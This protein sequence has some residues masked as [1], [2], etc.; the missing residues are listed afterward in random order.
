MLI[1]VLPSSGVRFG[2][3]C[4]EYPGF[5]FENLGFC[6]ENLESCFEHLEFCFENIFLIIVPERAGQHN[7][8][9]SYKR[10]W[11][12]SWRHAGCIERSPL[13]LARSLLSMSS[14]SLTATR[15][16]SFS[17]LVRGGTIIREHQVFVEDISTRYPE[18]CRLH[19]NRVFGDGV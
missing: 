1:F 10:V 16:M 14:R 18:R 4:F 2:T 6:F 12:G 17:E 3:F 9:I 7:R 15:F 5:C 19:T 11:E 8:R 13:S